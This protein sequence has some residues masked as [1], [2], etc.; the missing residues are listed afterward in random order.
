MQ[1]TLGRDNLLEINNVGVFQCTERFQYFDFSNGR[2]GE[3]ILFLLRIDAF[4]CD[5]LLVGLVLSDK[6]CP[7]HALSDLTFAVKHIIITQHHG[8]RN[9]DGRGGGRRTHAFGR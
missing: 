1:L 2:N 7:V 6:D 3:S 4:E 9:G 8:R 5:N